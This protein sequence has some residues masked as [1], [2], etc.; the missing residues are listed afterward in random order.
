MGRVG[1]RPI[2]PKQLGL[3]SGRAGTHLP[4]THSCATRIPPLNPH[5]PLECEHQRRPV[6]F[7]WLV[8]VERWDGDG[9]S[10]GGWVGRW[11]RW[12]AGPSQAPVAVGSWVDMCQMSGIGWGAWWFKCHG[13]RTRRGR[14]TVVR[15]TTSL[16]LRKREKGEAGVLRRPSS[17]PFPTPTRT[18][19]REWGR[20][21]GCWETPSSSLFQRRDPSL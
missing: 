20:G 7:K 12:V 16:P 9:S 2:P 15:R 11:G 18:S 3:L 4:P 21:G 17:P 5:Q 14:G 10:V 13:A 19:L 8:G 6:T 1:A